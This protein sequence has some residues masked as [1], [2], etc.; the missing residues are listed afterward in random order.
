MFLVVRVLC[1]TKISAT[2][3]FF[4]QDVFLKWDHFHCKFWLNLWHIDKQ[5]I[6][7][8]IRLIQIE[9]SQFEYTNMHFKILT[10]ASQKALT[11]LIVFLFYLTLSLALFVTKGA[12]WTLSMAAYCYLNWPMFVL[13]IKV[14]FHLVS[15]SLWNGKYE[16]K[17]KENVNKSELKIFILDLSKLLVARMLTVVHVLENYVAVAAVIVELWKNPG[18]YAWNAC[19]KNEPWA[20]LE[21]LFVKDNPRS[22]KIYFQ[23]FEYFIVIMNE[24]LLF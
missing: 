10:I 19:Q 1:T 6:W 14:P 3:I 9:Y 7:M 18:K 11:K 21:F 13:P 12:Y 5:S 17:Y 8:H 15:P 2:P 20:L 24:F 4:I 22:N 23:I 16:Q